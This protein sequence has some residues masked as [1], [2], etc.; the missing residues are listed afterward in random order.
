MQWVDADSVTGDD[1]V[2]VGYSFETGGPLEAGCGVCQWHIHADEQLLAGGGA[3]GEL[4]FVVVGDETL[5]TGSGDNVVRLVE[6][7]TA[8]DPRI[9]RAKVGILGHSQGAVNAATRVEVA[10]VYAAS[11]ATHKVAVSNGCDYNT[12]ELKAPLFI[13]TSDGR[14]D[15]WLVSPWSDVHA[16]CEAA[17]GCC[18]SPG[19][20][21]RG[22]LGIW[23]WV[24]HRV[25]TLPACGRH[26]RG[27]CFLRKRY[28]WRR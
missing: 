22:R 26:C 18:T 4:G 11:P 16:S 7:L 21:S 27:C 20:G 28:G 5:H 10:A 19:G 2:A 12:T 3:F 14:S 1:G 13:M 15:R 24:R 17:G 23:R 8:L 9:D 6:K 25:V